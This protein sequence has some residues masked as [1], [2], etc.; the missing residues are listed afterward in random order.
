M[1]GPFI[2]VRHCI[3]QIYPTSNLQTT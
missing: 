1:T 3:L 2:K